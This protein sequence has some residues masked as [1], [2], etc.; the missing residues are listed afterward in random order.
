MQRRSA[1]LWAREPGGPDGGSRRYGR[2]AGGRDELDTG[3]GVLRR[4]REQ[5]LR[6]LLMSVGHVTKKTLPWPRSDAVWCSDTRTVI[7]EVYEGLG[8]A[9]TEPM[10]RVGECDVEFEGYVVELDEEMHFNR[11]RAL[12]L[13]SKIYEKIGGFPLVL[14]ADYC[15]TREQECLKRHHGKYWSTP[16]AEELFGESGTPGDLACE[17]S[18]R[19][20]QRAFYDFVKDLSPLVGGPKVARVSI[21]DQIADSAGSRL[22]GDV[23]SKP[24]DDSALQI[25][26]LIETRAAWETN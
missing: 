2:G 24:V 9:L 19:Y 11:Y 6:N 5:S 8:G 22:L 20:K 14:Y 21:W 18:A 7:S 12:T 3:E 16:R 1:G 23:L 13:R 26:R 25:K 4:S 17:G 15:A 10:F